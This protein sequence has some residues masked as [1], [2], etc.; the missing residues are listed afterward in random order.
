MLSEKL[1]NTSHATK[2]WTVQEKVTSAFVQLDIDAELGSIPVTGNVGVRYV[3]TEQSSQ[4]NAFNVVDGLVVTSPTDI[5]HDYS[6]VLPSLNL[7]FRLDDSQTIRL[8]AAK[9]ISRARM[10]EMNASVNATYN[11][12][13][14]A[15]GN[16]WSVSGGNPALD[17]KKQQ[18][19]TLLMRTISQMKAISLRLSSTKISTLGYLTVTM[20]LI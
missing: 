13:P 6:H 5:D 1:T 3:K 9:T 2:S 16:N 14:D 18:V 20:T 8:G 10:D 4:G 17:R 11:Q 12:T 7:S 19:M 15:N